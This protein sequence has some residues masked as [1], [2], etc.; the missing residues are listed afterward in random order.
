M[1]NKVIFCKCAYFVIVCT[2]Y[3]E[4]LLETKRINEFI[5]KIIIFNWQK[6]P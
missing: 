1:H 4:I 3:E 6:R 2:Q 5:T